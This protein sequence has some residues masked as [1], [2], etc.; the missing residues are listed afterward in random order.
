MR[1]FS[2]HSKNSAFA[3]SVA[4]SGSIVIGSVSTSQHRPEN[5]SGLPSWYVAFT[6]IIIGKVYDANVAHTHTNERTFPYA[7]VLVGVRLMVKSISQHSCNS[8]LCIIAVAGSASPASQVRRSISIVSGVGHS[9]YFGCN[10]PLRR[11]FQPFGCNQRR[12]V[13]AAMP[14]FRV[15]SVSWVAYTD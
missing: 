8:H 14:S 4:Y 9:P 10:P 12:K 3:T 5:K 1:Q 6:I 11:P 2:V 7:V 15:F 13:A